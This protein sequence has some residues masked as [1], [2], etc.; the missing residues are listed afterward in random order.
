MPRPS[1]DRSALIANV[2]RTA[3]G[4]VC[5]WCGSWHKFGDFQRDHTH[6][7]G[8]KSH[9]RDCRTGAQKLRRRLKKVAS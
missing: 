4:K 2:R 5:T 9:C 3:R 7:D 8:L 6:P 1:I